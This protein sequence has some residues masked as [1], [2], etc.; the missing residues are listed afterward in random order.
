MG[1]GVG[2]GLQEMFKCLSTGTEETENVAL[3]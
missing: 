1:V 3:P 2:G